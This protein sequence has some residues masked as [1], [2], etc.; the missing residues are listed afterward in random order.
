MVV[1]FTSEPTDVNATLNSTV[2]WHCS[3]GVNG[4]YDVYWLVNDTR[5]GSLPTDLRFLPSGE[6]RGGSVFRT[7]TVQR[8]TVAY[9]NSRVQCVIQPD[10]G[11]IE[12][13]H[14]RPSILILQG[15]HEQILYTGEA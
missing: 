12:L 1:G 11:G 15:E 3:A 13:I 10:G 2:K 4:V 5:T 7:L 9:N 14:S 8:A 6:T